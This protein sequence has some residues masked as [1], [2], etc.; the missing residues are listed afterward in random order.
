MNLKSFFK[1]IFQLKLCLF[2]SKIY[3]LGLLFSSLTTHGQKVEIDSNFGEQNISAEASV[4]EDISG[5][6]EIEGIVNQVFVKSKRDSYL[7][8]FTN[9]THWLKFTLKN[10]SNK[11]KDLVVYWDN[12]LVE[13][14]SLYIPSEQKYTKLTD[15]P[16]ANKS[17]VFTMGYEPHFDVVQQA[18]EEITYFLKVKGR[19]GHYSKL[20]IYS[21]FYFQKFYNIDS[22]QRS[23]ISGLLIFRLLLVVIL[24]FF[25]VRDRGLFVYSFV[26]IAK[27]L[28]FWG[29]Q[30]VLGPMFSR[31]PNLVMKIDYA[32]YTFLPI[33]Y[34]IFAWVVLPLKSLPKYF[35]WLLAVGM[36]SSVVAQVGAFVW[37]SPTWLKFG[38][39]NI[40]FTYTMVYAMFFVAICKRLPYNKFYSLP[41]IFGTT[42]YF[43]MNARL[44]GYIEAP[45]IF[46]ISELL[47]LV[48]IFLFIFYLGRIFHLKELKEQKAIQDLTFSEEQTKKL[49]ELDSL[50]ND[51]FTNISHELRT[52]LTLIAG[53]VIEMEKQ[54]PSDGMFSIL[55]N[56]VQKLQ[57]LVDQIL[58]VQKLD[59]Q[60]M[61][62]EN[63]TFDLVSFLRMQVSSY[64]SVSASSDISLHM[65]VT[66]DEILVKADKDKLEI[67][68]NNLLSNALKYT[69]KGG[70]VHVHID[71]NDSNLVLTVK[72]TG[73]GIS[74]EILPHIFDR[75]FHK[76]GLANSKGTGIGLSLVKDLIELHSGTIRAYSDHGAVFVVEMPILA[77]EQIREAVNEVSD[78]E[79]KPLLLIVDDNTDMRSYLKMLLDTEYQIIEAE[80]GKE[81]LELARAHVPD[82]VITDLMMP[83]M[84][85]L[86]FAREIRKD[87]LCNH[88]PLMMLTASGSLAQ[89]LEGYQSGVDYYLT[90]PF[91]K[92]ELVSII[93]V[94]FENRKRLQEALEKKLSEN[95]KAATDTEAEENPFLVSIK[96]YLASNFQ[97]SGIGVNDIAT[98]LSISET[99]LRRKLKG[100][101][102]LSPNEFLRKYRLH[103]AAEFLRGGALSVSEV[104]FATG[105]ENLSYFTKIFQQAY[106]VLPSEFADK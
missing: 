15:I 99:Q 83:V 39:Q 11:P 79:D 90:K 38:I 36:V 19:R 22:A 57:R 9:A 106:G 71:R 93:N 73:S 2:Y 1:A 7:L 86:A 48:E 12:A 37:V 105:Y 78:T 53:P 72:D 82:I 96:E 27:T 30:N 77:T 103:K 6:K 29:I 42:G 8:P 89:K 104:A 66:E 70:A 65:D 69:P 13:E 51:F 3:L 55:K 92:N 43:F 102:G 49:L 5:K 46:Q 24:G 17:D 85:G 52:P 64:A 81:G 95:S 34:I 31:D 16:Y 67:I 23:L 41:F 60:K 80:N 10:T 87:A 18:G 63:T 28:G 54:Y 97:N 40:L 91:D 21:K 101:S 45:A 33:F 62:L 76:K 84:D 88:I 56:N 94:I 47:Y 68:I 4:Y 32:S 44:L 100:L 26:V 58:D 35:K 59:A 74:E 50:K 75:Y 14:V 98:G 25:V 61:E 20:M